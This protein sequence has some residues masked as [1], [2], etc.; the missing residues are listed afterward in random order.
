M[1]SPAAGRG[2]GTALAVPAAA[3]TARKR[4]RPGNAHMSDMTILLDGMGLL[5]DA[6]RLRRSAYVAA[7]RSVSRLAIL[8]MIRGTLLD[9]PTCDCLAHILV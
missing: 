8:T 5:G 3:G 9:N 2:E 1:A 7:M 4:Q 6:S